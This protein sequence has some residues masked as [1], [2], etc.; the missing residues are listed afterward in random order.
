MNARCKW[1]EF[2]K[3]WAIKREQSLYPTTW[4]GKLAQSIDDKLKE[5]QK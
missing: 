3:W 1:R 2:N 4:E 5:L